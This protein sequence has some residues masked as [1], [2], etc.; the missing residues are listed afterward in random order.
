MTMAEVATITGSP[1]Q[2]AYPRLHSARAPLE[3]A[4]EEREA[5]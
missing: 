1:L 5:P 4:L 2:T 3:E